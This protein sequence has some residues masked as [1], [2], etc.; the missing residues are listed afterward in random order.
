V[1]TGWLGLVLVGLAA[2][3]FSAT[4]AI[5]GYAALVPT[6]GAACV[7]MADIDG[8][9]PKLGAGR[10]LSLA[11]LAYIGARS[12]TF[13]LW[14]WPVL[15]I[16]LVYVG[17]GLSPGTNLLLLTGAFI[18]S[19]ITYK[20]FENPIRR[21]ERLGHGLLVWLGRGYPSASAARLRRQPDNTRVLIM[22]PA[23]A[24]LMLCVAAFTLSAIDEK[25]AAISSAGAPLTPGYSVLSPA[26]TAAPTAPNPTAPVGSAGHPL[27]SVTAAVEAADRKAA[28][29]T[30][31]SPP[32]SDLLDANNPAVEYVFPSGCAPESDSQT[33]S[34]V[35][36]LG[37]VGATKSIVVI[38]DSHA[39]MWMPP[40][41]QMAQTDSWVVRP[42]V[43]SG[44]TPYTWTGVDATAPCSAWFNW[45]VRQARLIR[46]SVMLIGA[47]YGGVTGSSADA[48]ENGITTL[49]AAVRRAATYVVLIADDD[50]IGEQPVDCLLG[51]GANMGTCTDVRSQASFQIND[52]LTSLAASGGFAV[53]PTR[54]WFCDGYQCPLVIGRTVVYRD[55]GHITV[56]Y[57]RTLYAPFR[58]E[59]RRVVGLPKPSGS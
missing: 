6:M 53:M 26:A 3:G 37:D 44:C 21:G 32:V 35:C 48:D 50:G 8:R 18:L 11:P 55:L 24:L 13:Y 7:I 58:A 22:W 38:G 46:P 23:S 16:A 14:H 9:R 28:I 27:P 40:I 57:A 12:Y 45:A 1:A 49:V 33:T 51:R 25:E 10:L 56:P 15:I 52:D 47:A 31:L 17:H 43:K 2:V 19:T 42:L 54:E 59:F 34:Q 39:Q 36:Q 29:P 41:L 4:T 30:D 20:V 5:P